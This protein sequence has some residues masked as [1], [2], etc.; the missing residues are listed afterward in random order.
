[1]LPLRPLAAELPGS[2][3]RRT[4]S[5]KSGR[6][7]PPLT[8]DAWTTWRHKKRKITSEGWV[9]KGREHRKQ[10]LFAVFLRQINP[11]I[12]KKKEGEENAHVSGKTH[13]SGSSAASEKNQRY[14][15]SRWF[16]IPPTTISASENLVIFW[17]KPLAAQESRARSWFVW[18]VVLGWSQHR[19]SPVDLEWKLFLKK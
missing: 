12:P 15:H 2:R 7:S 8:H 10:T 6:S 5:G 4:G 14:H 3:C 9:C 1:M 11:L 17:S 19:R 18:W 16:G 13:L